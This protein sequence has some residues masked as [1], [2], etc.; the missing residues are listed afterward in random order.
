VSE[1]TRQKP[2]EKTPV[3]ELLADIDS[4]IHDWFRAKLPF[5]FQGEARWT[6]PT[7]VFETESA[8]HVTMAI[9]GIRLEDMSVRF[10]H[11]ILV[12]RGVRREGCDD[13]R[14]Y[15]KMEIPAGP[16]SRRMRVGRPVKA[17]AIDVS[18]RDGMLRVTLPKAQ[19]PRIDVAID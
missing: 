13:S 1:K 10:E 19:A 16:F 12:V 9:P 4:Y 15:H 3:E 5:T 6:P 14:R 11:D 18:Y 8:I 7:D 17:D 2:R